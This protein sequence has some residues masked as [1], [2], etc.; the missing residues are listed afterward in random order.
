MGLYEKEINMTKFTI[1]QALL[2][3]E[4]INDGMI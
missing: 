4:N 1:K 3:F 2:Y